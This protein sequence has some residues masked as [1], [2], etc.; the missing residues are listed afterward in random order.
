MWTACCLAEAM[1]IYAPSAPFSNTELKVIMYTLSPG[2]CHMPS[3]QHT[4]LVVCPAAGEDG[5]D[6]L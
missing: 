6:F 3:I 2:H 1:R 5:L 4:F